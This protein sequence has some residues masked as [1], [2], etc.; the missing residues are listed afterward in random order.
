ME[1]VLIVEDNPELLGL[2]R[3][4]LSAEY[5]ILTARFG[6]E[7]IE[8]ARRNR[9]RVVIL[10]LQLPT[11]DGIEVGRWI[12]KELGERRVAILVLT[13]LAD[14]EDSEAIV[15]SGICDAFMAKPAHLS[16]IRGKVRELLTLTDAA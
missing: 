11:I 2:L 12:K 8:L 10:D 13:A 7:A 4:L 1:T 14:R 5:E 6:E 16:D 15:D 9:P 3:E